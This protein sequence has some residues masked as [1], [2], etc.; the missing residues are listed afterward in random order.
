MIIIIII[1]FYQKYRICSL[2]KIPTLLLTSYGILGFKS[3]SFAKVSVS[4]FIK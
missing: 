2:A 4:S 3:Q 1:I